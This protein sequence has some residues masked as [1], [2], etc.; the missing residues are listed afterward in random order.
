MANIFTLENIDDFSEKLNIDE[1]YEKKRQHDLKTLELFNKILNRIHV[2]I[3]TTSRHSKEQF[4]WYVVP[5]IMIGVPRYDQGACIAYLMDKLKTNGFNIRY[6]DPNMIFISWLHWV[7]SYV[8][9]EIK[10][11]MGININEFGEK[12][13]ESDKDN[14]DNK[15][16][17]NDLMLN[18]KENNQVQQNKAPKKNYTPINSYKPSGNLVYDD[19]LLLKIE[20]KFE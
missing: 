8:R 18:I 7:P 6:I 13:D 20:N 3:K 10:K 11:K 12:I 2:K 14:S 4:C 9:T 1:L 15:N 5:E 16:S 19:N 17:S